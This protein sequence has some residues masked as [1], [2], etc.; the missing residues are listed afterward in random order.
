VLTD[1]GQ[2]AQASALADGVL[3]QA[4]DSADALLVKAYTQLRQNG[5]FAALEYV[6][7]AQQIAP[8]QGYVLREYI[9]RCSG[10]A[11]PTRHWNWPRASPAC[12]PRPVPYPAGR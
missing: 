10:R 12:L 7:R 2:Q 8:G 1:S 4:P 9:L 11:W 6:D 5:S 3:R